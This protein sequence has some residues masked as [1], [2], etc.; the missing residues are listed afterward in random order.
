MLESRQDHGKLED[1]QTVPPGY[2]NSCC[3]GFI[4]DFTN[5]D[6][7]WK[8]SNSTLTSGMTL[9]M[10]VTGFSLTI[11]AVIYATLGWSV[12]HPV[13]IE[14][15]DRPEWRFFKGWYLLRTQ[16]QFLVARGWS[17]PYPWNK[18]ASTPGRPQFIWYRKDAANPGLI[19]WWLFHLGISQF[20]TFSTAPSGHFLS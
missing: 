13:I 19:W 11:N 1:S 2:H 17:D 3:H 15:C 14:S 6:I 9:S 12:R 8:G 10:H 7:Q 4:L 20:M 16:Q 5:G 18:L